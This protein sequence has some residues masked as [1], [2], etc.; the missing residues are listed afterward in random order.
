MVFRSIRWVNKPNLYYCTSDHLM[1]INVYKHAGTCY[2]SP[3]IGPFKIT[4][5]ENVNEYFINFTFELF[6]ALHLSNCCD[7]TIGHTQL[8]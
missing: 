6:L 7:V 1:S 8:V 3:E 4:S 5:V 2:M